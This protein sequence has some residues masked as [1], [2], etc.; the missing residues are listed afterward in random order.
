M[1]CHWSPPVDWSSVVLR[2]HP[3]ARHHFQDRL[4]GS[5]PAI[6]RR[7]PPSQAHEVGSTDCTVKATVVAPGSS[8]V[9]GGLAPLSGTPRQAWT[10][11]RPP[12]SNTTSSPRSRSRTSSQTS[13]LRGGSVLRALVLTSAA[14]IGPERMR[15]SSIWY[16]AGVPG[17]RRCR[18]PRRPRPAANS[19]SRLP[20]GGPGAVIAALSGTAGLVI[21]RA[22]LSRL[23]ARGP[24]RRRRRGARH[25]LVAALVIVRTTTPA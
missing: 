4:P 14:L 22:A 6:R 10:A 8:S 3:A 20:A 21:A 5:L 11:L 2:H 13:C 17:V 24:G 25:R 19:A 18:T 16:A 9:L 15:T 1:A 7:P 23:P 12:D